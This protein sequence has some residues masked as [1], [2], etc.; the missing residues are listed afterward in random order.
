MKKFKFTPKAA[1]AANPANTEEKQEVDA[2]NPLLTFA[3]AS[4]SHTD[5]QA[6][7]ASISKPL[8]TSIYNKNNNISKISNISRPD[9][10]NSIFDGAPAEIEPMRE[11]IHGGQCRYLDAP[12]GCRPI[13]SKAGIPVF[14]LD[15]CPVNQ[16][17]RQ[18]PKLSVAAAI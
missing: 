11:C 4:G 15:I 16:W 17:A 12:G 14:D 8:A 10:E 2:A 6:L 5:E 7:L 18:Q 1:K 9:N 13:C 3:K